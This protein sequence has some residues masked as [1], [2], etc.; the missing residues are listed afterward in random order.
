MNNSHGRVNRCAHPD[1]GKASDESVKFGGGGANPQEE[2]DLDEDDEERTDTRDRTLS[3]LDSERWRSNTYRHTILKTIRSALKEKMLAI[4]R[5]KHRIM[6][7]T[8]VLYGSKS[9]SLQK[10]QND[11]QELPGTEKRFYTIGNYIAALHNSRR[12]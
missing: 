11:D 3:E 8:P 6:H 5:A 1:R 4:P 12:Q 9:V 10:L 2:R 7:S